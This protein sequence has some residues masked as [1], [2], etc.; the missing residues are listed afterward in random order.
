MVIMYQIRIEPNVVTITKTIQVD[1][2]TLRHDASLRNSGKIPW[3]NRL[4]KIRN[5]LLAGMDL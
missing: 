4:A 3:R 1:P 5:K 2:V